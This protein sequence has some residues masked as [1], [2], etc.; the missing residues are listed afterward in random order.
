VL[1][2]RILRRRGEVAQAIEMLE[3]VRA[4]RP[5]KF[6]STD[7]EEAWYLCNRLLG[8]LYLHE[9]PDVAV[10]C[11]QEYRKSPK[12]GADTLYKLGVAYEN[13]GDR[14][15]AVKCYQQVAA[16]ESHPLAPEANDA[17]HRLRQPAG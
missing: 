14:P 1:R 15:K 8:D 12:S 4:N 10:Q 3:E 6:P 16:Y 5:E 2:A 13:L 17:L 11:F 7:E 9:K